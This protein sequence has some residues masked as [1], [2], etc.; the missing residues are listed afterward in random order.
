MYAFQEF[1]RTESMEVKMVPQGSV[2][3]N[4]SLRHIFSAVGFLARAW[5]VIIILIAQHYDR[6]SCGQSRT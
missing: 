2:V 6:G 3:D 1:L 5:H 4:V